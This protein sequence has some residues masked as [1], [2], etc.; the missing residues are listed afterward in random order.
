MKS[1]PGH[2]SS[3]IAGVSLA[4]ERAPAFQFYP[5]D[6]L[7]DIHVVSMSLTARG[8]YVTLLCL[9]WLEGSIPSEITMLARACGINAGAFGKLWPFLEPCFKPSGN[10]L[11]NKRLERERQKQR[12]YRRVKSDAGKQGGRPKHTESTEEADKKQNRS[13]GLTEKSP[14]SSSS[15]SSDRKSVV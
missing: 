10:R 13:R 15:S 6:F 14:P 5:K 11:I 3:P 12:E 9:C 2:P 1:E 7:T 8:A 4:A